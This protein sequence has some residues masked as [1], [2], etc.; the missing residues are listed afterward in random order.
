MG[1]NERI[2]TV[3]ELFGGDANEFKKAM[4]DLNRLSSFDEAK[5]Y[6]AANVVEKY[7]WTKRNKKGKAKVLIKTIR[8]RYA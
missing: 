4:T 1:L 6:L 3:N 7:G 2:L 8:R 5:Q